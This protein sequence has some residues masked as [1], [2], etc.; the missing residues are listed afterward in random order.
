MHGALESLGSVNAEHEAT[1]GNRRPGESHHWRPLAGGD[2]FGEET[3]GNAAGV[4]ER[5]GENKTR[6]V[7]ETGGVLRHF[8]AVRE[9]M[10]QG[11]ET[12]HGHAQGER[13]ADG[14]GDQHAEDEHGKKDSLLDERDLNVGHAQSPAERHDAEESRGERPQSAPALL[15]RP[16]ADGKH[17]EQVI[18]SIQRMDQS[19]RESGGAVPRVGLSERGN[20]DQR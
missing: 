5:R 20:E 7:G 1:H 17:G 8:R 3:G 18:P 14:G 15:R 6:S 12:D 11:K 16:Q 2:A 10:A 4:Q 9:A 13:K 19:V